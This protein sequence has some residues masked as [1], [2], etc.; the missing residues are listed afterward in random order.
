M[1]LTDLQVMIFIFNKSPKCTGL[2]VKGL[3]KKKKNLFDF[4]FRGVEELR[5]ENAAH[6]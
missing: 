2:S 5:Q 6:Q 4:F 1:I 3:E